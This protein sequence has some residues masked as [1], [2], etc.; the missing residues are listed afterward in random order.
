MKELDVLLE[1]FLRTEYASASTEQKHLFASLLELPDP[2]LAAY[3]FGH[4]VPPHPDAAELARLIA[5][6]R[7]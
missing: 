2:D 5:T 7:D 4:A 1:R 3:L 6:R